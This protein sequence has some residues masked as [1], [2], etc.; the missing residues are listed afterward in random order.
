MRKAGDII[1]SLFKDRFGQKFAARARSTAGLFSAWAGICA[2]AWPFAGMEDIPPAAAHSRIR[3][4][5][6]GLLLVEADHPGWVQILQTRQ[7]ELLSIARQRFPELDIRSISFCLSREPF[8]VSAVVRAETSSVS[9]AGSPDMPA[10]TEEVA[11]EKPASSGGG[12]NASYY[13]ALKR[14][15]K[16][17]IK[18]K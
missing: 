7:Q 6:R 4:L 15:E 14:L 17:I 9:A 13:K 8:S 12:D 16:S 1:E 5:E 3:E 18:R 2:E 11:A 10:T